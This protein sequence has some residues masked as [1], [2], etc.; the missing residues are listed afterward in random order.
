MSWV[1]T[2]CNPT[3]RG[4]TSHAAGT[5][6]PR[7]P[8]LLNE[9]PPP[10][11]WAAL[12]ARARTARGRTPCR[13]RAQ[14]PA[15]VGGRACTQGGGSVGAVAAGGQG[16]ETG[17]T[18][19]CRV[20]RMHEGERTWGPSWRQCGTVGRGHEGLAAAPFAPA[21]GGTVGRG[22]SGGWSCG[23]PQHQG[24]EQRSAIR[25][26]R[27]RGGL[28]SGARAAPPSPRLARRWGANA[29]PQHPPTRSHQ[30]L[31]SPGAAA[32]AGAA[33]A[34]AGARP[35]A[36]PRGLA[37]PQQ[38][39]LKQLRARAR[40]TAPTPGDQ[41]ASDWAWG[42]A[43]SACTGW[44]FAAARPSHEGRSGR[45]ARG[46]EGPQQAVAARAQGQACQEG[47]CQRAPRPARALSAELAQGEKADDRAGP[48][49][50]APRRRGRAQAGGCVA[51]KA[52]RTADRQ[53][54]RRCVAPST[55]W[56]PGEGGLKR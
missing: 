1:R 23:S 48:G 24:G 15:R 18:R 14:S 19:R 9:A 50:G 7:A 25:S 34:A 21:R 8:G 35:T 2:D 32:A 51:I 44:R 30:G 37:G 42:G 13:R 45:P 55:V 41:G 40:H 3:R 36:A 27:Q 5:A 10:Q 11:E 56:S 26:P 52:E 54:D 43:Q 6:R 33:P 16:Q 38:S 28:L 12:C 29:R 31:P 46:V 49:A 20:Q 4:P 17:P 47:L 39:I 22:A 53:P